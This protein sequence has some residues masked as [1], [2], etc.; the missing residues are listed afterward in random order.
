MTTKQLTIWF[1]TI[2]TILVLWGIVFA[3]FGLHI[4][5][6]VDR[7]VLLPW[8][9]ALYGAIMM[10]WGLTLL[11]IGRVAFR[12]NDAELRVALMFG[13][14]LWLT[15]EGAFSAY[16]RIWFNVG[17]DVAVLALFSFPL[18]RASRSEESKPM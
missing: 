12:R 17:V 3:F 11:L 1:S 2:S 10:G 18:L 9:S 15:V 16:F 7:A 8:E 14:A 4:L 13:I 6:V 5:P